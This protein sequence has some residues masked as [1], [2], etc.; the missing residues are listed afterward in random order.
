M[1]QKEYT[2]RWEI[3]VS[4]ESEEEA[5]RLIHQDYF[6]QDHFATVFEVT[7]RNAPYD[8]TV[9]DV[10]ADQDVSYELKY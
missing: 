8:I 9:V 10:K 5:A 1:S 2:V 7:E 6:K 3:E 4:A